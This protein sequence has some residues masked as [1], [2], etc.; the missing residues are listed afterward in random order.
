LNVC[1]VIL[2]GHDP[3]HH[4]EA[5]KDDLRA[6]RIAVGVP[7]FPSCPIQS[8]MAGREYVPLECH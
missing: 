1:K 5:A 6:I 2:A 4:V 7:V 8:R 3:T